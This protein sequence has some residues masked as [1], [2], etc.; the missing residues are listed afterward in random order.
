MPKTIT[1]RKLKKSLIEIKSFR[2]TWAEIDLD[3][4]EHNIRLVKERV[5]HASM[6]PVVKADAYGHGAREISSQLEQFHLPYLC[7]ALLEEAIELRQTGYTHPIFIIGPLEPYQIADAIHY[8]FTLTAHRMSIIDEI[9]QQSARQRKRIPFHIKID[10]GMGRLGFLPE[11][12]LEVAR[13]LEGLKSSYLEGAFSTFSSADDPHKEATHRQIKIFS[14][15]IRDLKNN[16]IYP[17]INHLA[18]SAAIINFPQSWLDAV[19]P[20]LLIYGINPPYSPNR[21]PVK[22]VLTLKSRMISLKDFPKDAPIGY[23]QKFITKR[24]SHIGILPIGYDDGITRS[25]YPGGEV[26]VKGKRAPLVGAVSMDLTAIDVTDIDGVSVGDTVTLIGQDGSET[27]SLSEISSRAKTI[28]Y[29]ILCGIGRRI[30]KVY[31]KHQKIHSFK[32]SILPD[33]DDMIF[34]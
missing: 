33:H 31:L 8:H 9:E 1:E 32:S 21:L 7:V 27:I 14:D 11:E 19:R 15:F 4:L 10:S 26:L 28:P 29:E 22:P 24:K 13:K 34:F 16:H 6:F 18:N 30:P 5:V 17:K 2:P 20:G 12:S 25:L 3:A 23:N